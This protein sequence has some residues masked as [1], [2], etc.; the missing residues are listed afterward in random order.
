MHEY[1][2]IP[3]TSYV[4]CRPKCHVQC[5]RSMCVYHALHTSTHTYTV[6]HS[7]KHIIIIWKRNRYTANSTNHAAAA[8]LR[9]HTSN[10]HE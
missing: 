5:I 7:S 3:A 6:C 9:T 8:S 10:E 2:Y 1:K 4:I